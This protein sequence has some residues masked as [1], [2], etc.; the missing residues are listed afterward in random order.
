M[1][2]E[3]LFVEG[4]ACN[5]AQ[6]L[7]NAPIWDERPLTMVKPFRDH[8]RRMGWQELCCP[9]PRLG[10]MRLIQEF[11]ANLPFAQGSL[12]YVRG[13][14]VDISPDS[15]NHIFQI[16]N[17]DAETL[18]TRV[19]EQSLNYA[20][21][22]A[23]LLRNNQVLTA[24]SQE[25]EHS[26]LTDEAWTWHLFIKARLML[27]LEEPKITMEQLHLIY[28]ILRGYTVNPGQLIHN[29]LMNSVPALWQRP[30]LFFPSI[31]YKLC[32][33]AGVEVEAIPSSL[34]LEA[35]TPSIRLRREYN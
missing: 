17:L 9:S 33:Q 29:A 6:K 28:A 8:I 13:R 11:F 3:D 27:Q 31:I 1:A 14:Q 7:T 4:A 26:S 32:A 22:S 18:Y 15:I 5:L 12:V 19:F 23:T 20:D 24:N 35:I 34:V 2:D 16:Q 10:N 25:I 21:L 30:T